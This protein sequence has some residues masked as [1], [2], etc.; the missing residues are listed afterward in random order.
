M[1]QYIGIG[2]LMASGIILVIGIVQL[3]LPNKEKQPLYAQKLP[4]MKC[5]PDFYD[6]VKKAYDTTTSVKGMLML[7]ESQKIGRKMKLRIHA[8][9]DYL[10]NSRFRD[11]E[12]TLLYLYNGSREGDEIIKYVLEQEILKF[13][14]IECRREEK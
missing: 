5:T 3:L 13:Q 1:Y 8:A 12:N 10:D 9:I 7:L 2:L 11:Y 4:R 6:K 14:R